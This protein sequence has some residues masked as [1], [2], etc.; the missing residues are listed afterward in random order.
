MSK[1]P[2]SYFQKVNS[3]AKA[4]VCSCGTLP[5]LVYCETVDHV[6]Q[7]RCRQEGYFPVALSFARGARHPE[8]SY[9]CGAQRHTHGELSLIAEWSYSKIMVSKLYCAV[10]VDRNPWCDKDKGRYTIQ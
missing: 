4:H 3:R 1:T 6:D 8:E 5:L 10:S 9:N 2:R 7:R